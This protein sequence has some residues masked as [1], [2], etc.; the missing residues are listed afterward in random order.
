MSDKRAQFE[1]LHSE[2]RQYVF[3]L[4]RKILRTDDEAWDAVQEIFLRKW[5]VFAAYDPARASF[6]TF[7]AAI[8][9]II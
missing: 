5:R 7:L 2:Y 4:C 3:T 6:R 9:I 8:H 1:A